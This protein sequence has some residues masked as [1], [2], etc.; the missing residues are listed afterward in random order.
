MSVYRHCCRGTSR[1]EP[2]PAATVERG[3][4]VSAWALAVDFSTIS[5]QA[6]ENLCACRDEGGF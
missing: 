2:L 6:K 5:R 1:E 4:E 3:F